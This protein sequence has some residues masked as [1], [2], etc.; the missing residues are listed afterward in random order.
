MGHHG[1]ANAP[2]TQAGRLVHQDL[3]GA[4]SPEWAGPQVR[5]LG[6][7]ADAHRQPRSL[8]GPPCCSPLKEHF[9]KRP[10]CLRSGDSHWPPC[11]EAPPRS[12]FWSPWSS[13]WLPLPNRELREDRAD[14]EVPSGT[15]V[16]WPRGGG[17]GVWAPLA[18]RPTGTPRSF[19]RPEV[20]AGRRTG[21]Q[22]GPRTPEVGLL[23]PPLPCL[24]PTQC[25]RQRP[26]HPGRPCGR[27]GGVPGQVTVACWA[28]QP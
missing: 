10:Q 7:L 5:G 13:V 2:L 27:V 18:G 14:P 3:G 21:G 8:S 15:H 20:P 4:Q 12:L 22:A 16:A 26:R 1:S 17:G 28:M 9:S 25:G 11:M 24:S 19:C 23:L 6:L